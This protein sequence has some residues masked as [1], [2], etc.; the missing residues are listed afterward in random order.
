MK[1][2]YALLILA[3]ALLAPSLSHA[4]WNVAPTLSYQVGVS[5]VTQF[6]ITVST[7]SQ[8]A[9]FSATQM[10]K[11]QLPGRVTIEI[12]NIDTAANLWC[13]IGSTYVVGGIPATNNGRKIAAGGS[14]IVSLR[15]QVNNPPGPIG[16]SSVTERFFCL[17][18]GAAATKAWVTQL[19]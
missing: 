16:G 4:A 13:I 3:G 7:S 8:G 17:T 6:L 18:D 1:K 11:P 10:D 14:W 5:S 9:G 15:D 19:Y 12:Q 2:L